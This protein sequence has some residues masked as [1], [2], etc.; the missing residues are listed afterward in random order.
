MKRNKMPT[1][2]AHNPLLRTLAVPLSA[3]LLA[4]FG[5]TCTALLPSGSLGWGVHETPSTPGP[6]YNS[7]E[8]D[9]YNELYF[10][11][12][13]VGSV[14]N[15]FARVAAGDGDALKVARDFLRPGFDVLTEHGIPLTVPDPTAKAG[16]RQLT[17]NTSWSGWVTPE[18]QLGTRPI[19]TALTLD[20]VAAGD[21]RWRAHLINSYAEFN[22]LKAR[23]LAIAA[24]LEVQLQIKQAGAWS[25][26]KIDRAE[27][28]EL[29]NA[30]DG[31]LGE[32]Y[33]KYLKD[34]GVEVTSPMFR[35]FNEHKH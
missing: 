29:R 4:V 33:Y 2:T 27:K 16:A 7:F 25:Y 6:D 31:A 11:H 3:A 8:F 21:C 17:F 1:S 32:R 13:M 15:V 22:P 23:T 12:S 5:I 30:L 10:A 34:R 20:R 35:G 9:Y 14:D 28:Q 18:L 24:S 19:C 26:A